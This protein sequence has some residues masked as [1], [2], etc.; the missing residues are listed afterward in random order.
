M[1]TAKTISANSVV[2][3]SVNAVLISPVTIGNGI[4]VT[5]P[6]SSTL[7]IFAPA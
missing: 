7:Y 1:A 3:D 5:V 6:T 2:A 4:S